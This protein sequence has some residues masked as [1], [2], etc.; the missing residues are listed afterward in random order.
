MRLD[1]GR[2]ARIAAGVVALLGLALALETAAQE[3]LGEAGTSDVPA[4]PG[5]VEGRLVHDTRP[6]AV[7]E[8]GV[9]LYALA[10]DG[11][12]GLRQTRTDTDGRFRFEGISNDAG[13]VYLVGARPGD[14]P[15][16]ERF[17]FEAGATEHRLTLTLSDPV[18]DAAA[19]TLD[20]LDL[21]VDRACDE[22]R[23]VHS[24]VLENPGESVI[25]VPESQ[26]E[27]AAPLFEAEIPENARGFESLLERSG[28]ERVGTRVRF[29]GPLYPGLQEI[30]FGYGLPSDTQPLE[31]AFPS[32]SPPLRILTPEGV[33]G[34]RSEG[35][36]A[37]PPVDLE[38][39]SYA[40]I[41][42]EAR[43]PRSRLRAELSIE[44]VAASALRTER[45]EWWIEVDDAALDVNERVAVE[46]EAEIPASPG[47]PLFCLALPRDATGLRFS[48]EL[49]T[50]GLRRDPGGSL[51][52]HG[53][54]PA[55]S[56]QW[57][58]GYRL[59]ATARGAEILRRFDRD[60]PLL[61]VLVADTGVIAETDRLHRRRSVRSGDRL[62]LHLEAFALEAGETL[63]LGLRRTAPRSDRGRWAATGFALLAGLAAFGF[64]AS[65]LRG[66]ADA[67]A[68][69]SAEDGDARALEMAAIRRSL[70]DLDDDL[71]TGKLTPD[72]HAVMRQALRARAAKLLLDEA[73]SAAPADDVCTG[74]GATLAPDASFCGQCGQPRACRACGAVP[75]RDDRFCRQ[76][77]ASLREPGAANA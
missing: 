51:A 58:V 37:L 9:V 22:L 2:R 71:E 3:P 57:A 19:V 6:E 32:G 31:L 17:R 33:I 26:R 60:L 50:A 75:E 15:F 69:P 36:S 35:F 16:G 12:A 66:D 39:A 67:R 13:V 4:G 41:G 73:P 20:G 72:D 30:P 56:H 10:E 14:I 42:G 25:F 21:R 70:A 48:N 63:E 64:L 44:T 1:E 34:A 61:S 46:I 62:Y 5:R 11:S 54:L 74:C 77:G 68:R 59:P 43:P 29:W 49:L 40:V 27:N 45:A 7:A 38:G 24:Y 65:P 52:L 8:V 76:C 18:S 55:G 47:A 23:I 53:P 28:L